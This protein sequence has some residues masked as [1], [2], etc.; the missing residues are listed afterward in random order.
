M[1]L[2]YKVSVKDSSMQGLFENITVI[3]YTYFINMPTAFLFN[4]FSL[5][6]YELIRALVMTENVSLTRQKKQN[7]FEDVNLF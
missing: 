3:T 6:F 1:S 4:F 7:N 2:D 5:F